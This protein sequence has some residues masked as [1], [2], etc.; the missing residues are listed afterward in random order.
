MGR[1]QPNWEFTPGRRRSLK[2]ARKAVANMKKK[3]G[4]AVITKSNVGKLRRHSPKG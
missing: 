3:A 1:K 2:K 4:L